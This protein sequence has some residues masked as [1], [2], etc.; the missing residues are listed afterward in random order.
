MIPASVIPEE[1][2]SQV[3]ELEPACC[4]NLG[5]LLIEQEQEGIV[6]ALCFLQGERLTF[7][8]SI[9][10]VPKCVL[11]VSGD[12]PFLDSRIFASQISTETR[13]CLVWMRSAVCCS[14]A[15]GRC[16]DKIKYLRAVS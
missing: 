11:S 1:L 13:G 8:S 4:Q 3:L 12:G 9:A 6:T 2:I 15:G 16:S 5:E 7:S 10:F 14:F